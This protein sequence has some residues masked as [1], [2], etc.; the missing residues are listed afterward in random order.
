MIT[1]VLVPIGMTV[2]KL[3]GHRYG[4]RIPVIPEKDENNN[5]IFL[6]TDYVA[7]A[8]IGDEKVKIID[9]GS[10]T[11]YMHGDHHHN[12]INIGVGERTVA[13]NGVEV[14]NKTNS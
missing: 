2:E 11:I 9:T 4:S 14:I 10:G 8:V 6:D 13:P 7:T 5:I 1:E 12:H 3:T